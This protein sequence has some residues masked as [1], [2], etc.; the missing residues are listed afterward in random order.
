MGTP[1]WDT[2]RGLITAP[3]GRRARPYLVLWLVC[4]PPPQPPSGT[5]L[6]PG[7]SSVRQ[8]GK[9]HLSSALT[10]GGQAECWQITWARAPDL[11]LQEPRPGQRVAGAAGC[12]RDPGGPAG[13]GSVRGPC[14]AGGRL[15]GVP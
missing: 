10:G 8:A 9:G 2:G 11:G 4:P 14:E 13:L 6:N 3:R 12:T 7:A 5:L 15:R 1:A